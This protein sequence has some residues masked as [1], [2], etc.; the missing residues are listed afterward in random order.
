M[1]KLRDIDFSNNSFTGEFP[2]FHE[3]SSLIYMIGRDNYLN[4]IIPSN[5]FKRSLVLLDLSR[6]NFTGTIPNTISNAVDLLYFILDNNNLYGSI[7]LNISNLIRFIDISDNY[8]NFTTNGLD[9]LTSLLINSKYL[10]YLDIHNNFI[11]GE[12]NFSLLSYMKD[13]MEIDFSDNLFTSITYDTPRNL[14]AS[15]FNS[16][17]ILNISYNHI[18]GNIEELFQYG[19]LNNL[20]LID[21]T[22]NKLSG[23]IPSTL[24]HSPNLVYALLGDNCFSGPI[25]TSICMAEKLQVVMLDGASSGSQCESYFPNGIEALKLFFNLHARFVKQKLGGSIPSCLWSLPELSIL[26]LSGN[27]ITGTIFNSELGYNAS[28]LIDLNLAVNSL[29]GVIPISI[30]QKGFQQ[31]DLSNNR[32]SGELN[33]LNINKDYINSTLK[34]AQNRLSGRLSDRVVHELE[35]VTNLDILQGNFF[36][37]GTFGHEKQNHLPKTDKYYNQYSCLGTNLNISILSCGVIVL[38]GLITALYYY[39]YVFDQSITYAVRS[40]YLNDDISKIDERSVTDSTDSG[41]DYSL[42]FDSTSTT[43]SLAKVLNK[44][45]YLFYSYWCYTIQL[46]RDTFETTAQFNTEDVSEFAITKKSLYRCHDFLVMI[47]RFCM[48]SVTILAFYLFVCLISYIVMKQNRGTVY[49]ETFSFTYIHMQSGWTYTSVFLHGAIP[50]F[51]LLSFF[52]ISIYI[53]K[54][55]AL[56]AEMNDMVSLLHL[57]YIYSHINSIIRRQLKNIHY[58]KNISMINFIRL[59]DHLK[60]NIYYILCGAKYCYHYLSTLLI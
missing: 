19:A 10:K 57:V 38:I 43:K 47:S 49:D 24:F 14:L 50:V 22:H 56:D 36:V 52:I 31:L 59:Q 48:A 54:N 60:I 39:F 33:H 21:L 16:L 23:G 4:G 2:I 20:T 5:L 35:A 53:F 42:S 12:I 17:S 3:N 32:F 28:K 18:V 34:L 1:L 55:A 58:T 8:F 26:H 46:Y 30:Q 6:N 40:K 7:P 27:G 25:S 37:C 44:V 9:G 13:L 11:E 29:S 15:N 51:L 45:F 41:I